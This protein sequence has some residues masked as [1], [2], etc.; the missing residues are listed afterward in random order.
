VLEK[1]SNNVMLAVKLERG[2]GHGGL[3]RRAFAVEDIYRR[4]R[5]TLVWQ[6]SEGKGRQTGRADP[7]QGTRIWGV[8]RYG[9]RGR[10]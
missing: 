5:M 4:M 9:D 7:K 10:G 6:G 8:R 3:M 1:K 2:G